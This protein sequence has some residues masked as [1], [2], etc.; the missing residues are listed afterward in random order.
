MKSNINIELKS[1]TWKSLNS[2]TWEE[3]RS[4]EEIKN[5]NTN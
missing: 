5:V 3:L 4:R 2:Y 1:F